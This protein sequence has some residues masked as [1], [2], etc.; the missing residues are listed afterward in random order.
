MTP[1]EKDAYPL[2]E[3]YGGWLFTLGY[4]EAAQKSYNMASKFEQDAIED[5]PN[6]D[7]DILYELFGIDR[8]KDSTS[9][10]QL[11]Q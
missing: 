2:H 9:Q 11:P 3:V 4:K 6:Y 10:E 5:I 8:R 7:A 1:E